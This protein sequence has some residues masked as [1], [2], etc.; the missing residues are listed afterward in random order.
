M[1]RA[2]K[3]PGQNFTVPANRV[4]NGSATS[5]RVLA[6]SISPADARTIKR[7]IR[8]MRAAE[9]SAEQTCPKLGK[10]VRGVPSR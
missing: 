8:R 3:L 2:R 10:K 9:T 6:G 7:T 1:L 4:V 5:F